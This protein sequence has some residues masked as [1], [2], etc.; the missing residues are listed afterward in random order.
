[1]RTRDVVVY[2]AGLVTLP[3]ALGAVGLGSVVREGR[4]TRVTDDGRCAACPSPPD[5]QWSPLHVC[6]RCG[7]RRF[8]L[9]LVRVADALRSR[10]RLLAW[11]PR[12]PRDQAWLGGGP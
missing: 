1:M 6:T 11:V 4:W 2:A 3:A 8:R 10:D 7:A 5:P 12:G 9:Y